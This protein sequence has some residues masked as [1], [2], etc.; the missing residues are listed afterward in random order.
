M[1][2]FD[3]SNLI[4]SQIC[5]VYSYTLPKDTEG[6]AITAHSVILIKKKG[7]SEYVIDGKKYIANKENIIFIPAGTEYSMYV[8]RPGECVM[9]E[10][11]ALNSGEASACEF[12]TGDDK[13]VADTVKSIFHYW[14]L[15]GPA[16]HSKCLSELYSFITQLS[17]AHSYA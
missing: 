9:I 5:D 17:T 6:S 13:D 1:K 14:K 10:F 3:I 4:I 16:Y 12:F 2:K 8:Y 15:K 7:S 11:D